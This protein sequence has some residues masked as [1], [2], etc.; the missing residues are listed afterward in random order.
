MERLWIEEPLFD[1]GLAG[2]AE[3]WRE[4]VNLLQ[5]LTILVEG[6]CNDAAVFAMGDVCERAR[7]E[8]RR[9][10]AEVGA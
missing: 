7:L 10:A 3:A 5:P 6:L 2:N 8:A 1:Y 9:A 4:A